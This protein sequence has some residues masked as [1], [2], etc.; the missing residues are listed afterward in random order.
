MR[1]SGRC[2]RRDV[3]GRPILAEDQSHHKLGSLPIIR[4]LPR[5][6]LR[7]GWGSRI[8]DQHAFPRHG[9]SS[10]TPDGESVE[11]DRSTEALVLQ[12]VGR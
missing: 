1:L 2:I 12:Y 3:A 9:S 10:W 4:S 6:G 11:S 8:V 7:Q 5:P